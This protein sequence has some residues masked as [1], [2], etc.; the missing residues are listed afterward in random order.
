MVAVAFGSYATSL[1]VGDD[2][3]GGWDNVFTS[4]IVVAMAAINLVGSRRRRP[5]PV[6]DRRRPAR[7]LRRLHRRHAASTSTLDLLAFSGYPPVSD[8]VASVA[9]TFFAYLGFSVIT[10]A[11][12]DLRDPARELPRAMYA[13]AR[14]DDASS[15]SSSRSASSAR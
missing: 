12:G 3:A 2:A 10:F 6:A 11:V 13:R 15:T 4:A 5:S 14:R 7:R 1:F 8:I 9:L